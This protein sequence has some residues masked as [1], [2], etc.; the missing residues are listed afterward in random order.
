MGIFHMKKGIDAVVALPKKSKL[1]EGICMDFC[2]HEKKCNLPRMQWKKYK[3]Y[4]TWKDIPDEDKLV[5]LKHMNNT[6]KMWLDANTFLKNK[7]SIVAKVTHLLGDALGPKQ[8]D[9]SKSM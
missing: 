9:T 7:L 8:K 1:K 5:L 4:T 6:K 2:L 3:H